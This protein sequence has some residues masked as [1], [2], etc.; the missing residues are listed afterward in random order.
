MLRPRFCIRTLLRLTLTAAIRRP[1][2]PP[3]WWLLR[4]ARTYGM[5]VGSVEA[6]VIARPEGADSCR[7]IAAVGWQAWQYRVLAG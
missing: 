1:V 6:D 5:R 4:P 3:F 2:G 7:S